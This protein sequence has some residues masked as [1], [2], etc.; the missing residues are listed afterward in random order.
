MIPTLSFK[1]GREQRLLSGSLWA[2]RNELDFKEKDH[3]P[4]SLVRLVS[5]KGRPL[6]LGFLNSR[7]LIAVR[8]LARE[9]EFADP[10]D[11]P[12]LLRSRLE[13]ALAWR[14]DRLEGAEALRLVFS[15]G[16]L[17][18]GLVV[19][20]FGPVLVAQITSLGLERHRDFLFSELKRLTG[21]RALVERSEGFGREKEG[22][23]PRSGLVWSEPGFEEASLPA[24]RF[25][26]GEFT[27]QA[28]L[29]KGQKT[30]FFLDQR[31]TRLALAGMARGRRCLNAFCYS[32]GFS[33]ALARGGAS[34]VLGVDSSPE[35]LELAGINAG[36][37]QAPACEFRQADVFALL[38]EME[39]NRERFD[40][41]VLDPPAMTKGRGSLEDALRGYKE[42][43]Y[44]ALK[45]LPTGGL[46]V[47]CS[48]SQA[49]DEERFVSVLNAAA[50][51]AGCLLQQVHRGGQGA[52]HPVLAGMPETR[53]LKVLGLVKR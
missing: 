39:K 11:V 8:V 29:L 37:N 35:A 19:D 43:N 27:F 33:V 4:G 2:F 32:G 14:A 9:G 38:R 53:Y 26:E 5:A 21:C 18:S 16:D 52:D 20:R 15:E 50:K 47:T 12:A 42:I 30:G 7:S 48:C 40:L 3:T 17:L 10:E 25:R 23:E 22:L 51:D 24:L 13:A 44:R 28:D 49:V 31:D 34:S 1:P 41:V 36:L 6:A 46:L 45:L